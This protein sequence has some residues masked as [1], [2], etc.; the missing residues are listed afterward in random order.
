MRVAFSSVVAAAVL[1]VLPT[2]ALA[3]TTRVPL[4]EVI[5]DLESGDVARRDHAVDVLTD[6]LNAGRW[7]TEDLKANEMAVIDITRKRIVELLPQQQNERPNCSNPWNIEPGYIET[8]FELELLLDLLA[9]GVSTTSD[10]LLADSLG[11]R[12]NQLRYFTI[13]SLAARNPALVPDG[14]WGDIA[15]DDRYRSRAYARIPAEL[16][17]KAPAAL[18]TQE[19]LARSD[20]VTQL[21]LPD[22]IGCTPDTIRRTAIVDRADG[23]YFVF[24]LEPQKGKGAYAGISGPF[25]KN[26]PIRPF[27]ERT[28]ADGVPYGN[29]TP[30]RHLER[31]L[32]NNP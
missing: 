26:G 9:V 19:Q 25:P 6:V 28:T 11:L 31:L 17:A 1:A 12:D 16:R 24:R 14:V 23:R 4:T 21:A 30:R 22:A 15:N 32:A 3:V 2:A 8:A 27:G 20:L 5:S 18:L 7:P 29:T 10:Q 13:L